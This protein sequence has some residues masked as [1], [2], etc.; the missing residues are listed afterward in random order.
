[1]QHQIPVH[2]IDQ[3][4][5]P[6]TQ[7]I[8]K[9]VHCGFCLAACPT[10]AVLGE[11]MDS[12]RGRIYLMK[13]VLEGNLELDD[14]TPY[15]DR[16]L[17]C[18]GCE[19]ACP[20]GVGYG[21]LISPFRSYANEK[22]SHSLLSRLMRSLTLAT[23]PYP[24]RLRWAIEFG[25]IGKLMKPV[26]P[27]SLSAPLDLLP[28]SVPEPVSYEPLYEPIGRRR[29]RVALLTGC[30]QQVLA[31]QINATTIDV[32]RHNGVQVIVPSSQ[33]CCG[34]MAWHV[35]DHAKATACGRRNFSAFP[36]PA[37]VDAIITNAAGCGSGIK[38]YPLIFAD[39]AESSIADAFAEKSMDISVFLDR[40]GLVTPAGFDSI[41]RVVYQDACHL[42]N[43]QG[44]KQPP[45]RI[46][47]SIPNVEL[48]ELP[49]GGRCCGSAGT[50]NIDQPEIAAELGRMKAQAV[51]DATPQADCV[52]T[53]NIGC[54][55]QIQ[56]YL[57]DDQ[58]PVLH[59]M[60][61]LASAYR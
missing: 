54:L 18:L 31:P 17:G 38:E 35:G 50:Y 45:R 58:V 9:C 24:N 49:D 29:A 32:L 10:Y 59:I 42:G 60:E 8:E 14:A 36:D 48:V 57:A 15:I 22:R 4:A 1:M 2:E 11:E 43:A 3:F 41:K 13:Q 23:L 55:V 40:L 25:K 5:E 19:P 28:D 33:G 27:K 44:I 6:M 30:A 52:A 53:G 34:A 20:S 12:P 61:L 46:L 26:L 7:A 21:E 16:C 47:E 39:E 37:D 51:R 56:T